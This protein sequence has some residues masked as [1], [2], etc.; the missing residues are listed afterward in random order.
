MKVFTDQ[1]CGLHVVPFGFPECPARLDVIV[2]GLRAAG[3]NIVDEGPNAGR[4]EAIEAVHG[5]DY[6]ARFRRSVERGEGLFGS[7]DT[8]LGPGTW[9][10]AV[11]A[12]DATLNGLDWVAGDVG[13]RA[14]AA[15]RPPGH[16]A[17]RELAMGFC[18]FNN[19]A[20]AAE[21][22]RRVHR[23][24]RI[25]IFDLDVHHGN[26]TAHLFEDDPD[27]LYASTHQFPFYPGSG[28]AG[29]VGVGAGVR[30]TVNVPLPSGTGDDGYAR[31]LDEVILPALEAHAPD[32]LLLSVGFD[33]WKGDQLGGMRVTA[34]GFE[35]WGR[36]LGTLADRVCEGRTLA[37]LEGGYDL[38]A[39]PELG[40]RFLEGLRDGGE[41]STVD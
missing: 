41:L 38:G 20:I 2:R 40:T 27:V 7:A 5:E 14:F 31:A 10:A 18:Y 13:R 9:E 29:E 33:A 32:L 25:A 30:T 23:M 17:E 19:V 15:V 3:H 22:A 26:G 37:V 34:A 11:G 39:L 36:R 6:P 21:R 12:V 4:N 8:P 28:A 24:G 1:R 16:H 35:A